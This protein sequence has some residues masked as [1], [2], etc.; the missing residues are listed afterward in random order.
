[1]S[2]DQ[3]ATDLAILRRVRQ[4]NIAERYRPYPK[5]KQF[6]DIG[7]DKRERLFMAGNQIG[8]TFAGAMEVSYHATGNYPVWWKGRRFDHPVIIMVGS[9]TAE[10]TRDGAQRLLLGPPSDEKMWGT[11]TIPKANIMD[12][13]RR[14][15][16][17]DAIDTI[18][19]KHRSGG[20]STIL[21]KSYDQGRKKWQ[22]NTVHCVWF[23]EEPPYDVYSEGLTR[24]TRTRGICFVTFTPL[25]GRS[26]VVKRYTDEPSPDR[27]VVNMTIDDVPGISP[28]EKQG[29]IDG[30]PEH[31][32]EA[33][34]HGIPFMGSGR[35]YMAPE[36][37]IKVEPFDTPAHWPVIDAVDF[38]I[39]HNFAWVRLAWDRDADCIYLIDCFKVK[40]QSAI[41]HVATV[42]PKGF[43]PTAWPRDGHTKDRGSGKQIKNI[44]KEQ[45]MNML[46]EAATFEDGRGVSVEAGIMDISDRSTTNRFKA[47][48]HLTPFFEEYRLYHRKDGIIVKED[49]DVLDAVRYGVMMKRYA[50]PRPKFGRR[51]G[52]IKVIGRDF[53]VLSMKG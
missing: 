20:Q 53:D 18:S 3:L 13:N 31:E 42:R 24:I 48:S 2:V 46:S 1:M 39:G 33:R 17:S 10:L 32:R 45:G 37:M 34:A 30:W 12:W 35:I 9:E 26:S 49:D 43:A 21:F 29:I 4:E 16:V 8:K 23:D 41:M 6:H 27:E 22:A 28:E 44:Y 50:K 11:G 15:G 38:G 19:V 52:Q 7:R 47:F 14:M 5:Q 40:G 25:L 51:K 36:G